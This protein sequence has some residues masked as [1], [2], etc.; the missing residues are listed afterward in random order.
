MVEGVRDSKTLAPQERERLYAEILRQ[1]SAVGLGAASVAEIDA[2]N[3]LRASHLAM[4]RALARVTPCDFALVD[5]RP[6]KG[7]DLG[8]HATM[9]DGDATSYAIACA[10]IV[11]KVTR[12]RLMHKLARRFPG[13]GWETNVGY[14][15]PGHL[16]AL[17]RLGLTPLHRR[18]YAP[19][20]AVLLGFD[21]G[22]DA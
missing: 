3:V 10:S 2:L 7:T 1:A 12:D 13:Y 21:S 11:A 17:R 19:V 18:S 16:E 15:T 20:Q 22:D 6:V 9:I 14:G 4:R 8:P 5:G